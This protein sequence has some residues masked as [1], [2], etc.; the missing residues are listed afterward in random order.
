VEWADK[1]VATL[2][3]EHLQIEIEIV[4][5]EQRRFHLTATGE[6]YSALATELCGS[7]LKEAGEFRV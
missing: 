4:S 3:D 1:V 2:P 6:R 7:S 5:E